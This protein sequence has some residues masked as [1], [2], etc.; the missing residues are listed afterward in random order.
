MTKTILTNKNIEFK[1][2][3]IDSLPIVEKDKYLNI[4]QENNQMSFPIIFQDEELTTLQK[5][6]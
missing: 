5:I 6:K 1:Y 2:I 3:L 4:A